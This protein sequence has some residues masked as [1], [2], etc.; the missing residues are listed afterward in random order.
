LYKKEK[1]EMFN[2]DIMVLSAIL[3][4]MINDMIY[5]YEQIP[6]QIQIN[7]NIVSK[8]HKFYIFCS[9]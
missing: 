3:V 2:G 1:I 9:A 6:N 8:L 5:N 7:S 4:L